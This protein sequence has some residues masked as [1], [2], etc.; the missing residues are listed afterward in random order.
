MS[1]PVGALRC[2]VPCGLRCLV[3]PPTPSPGAVALALLV[4]HPNQQSVTSHLV[5]RPPST[6]PLLCPISG[7]ISIRSVI[8]AALPPFFVRL[9]SSF[10]A[11]DQRLSLC[12]PQYMGSH[13]GRNPVHHVMNLAIN[14]LLANDV[15]DF[16]VA[17][18]IF[19]LRD[20]ARA[21]EAWEDV[22]NVA[23]GRAW[24]EAI[25]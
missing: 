21:C 22:V 13:Q 7:S 11:A 4:P 6:L 3:P 5:P 12:F 23:L 8:P 17:A 25:P 18:G 9:A 16:P 10:K 19:N 2:S 1:G 15:V 14:I 24:S 20:V